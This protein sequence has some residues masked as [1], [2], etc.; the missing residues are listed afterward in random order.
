MC[1]PRPLQVNSSAPAGGRLGRAPRPA[2]R[3]AARRSSSA[4]APSR[5]CMRT[6]CPT[7][8]RSPTAIVPRLG[9]GADDRADEEVA[10]LVLG[11]VLVDHDPEHQA[12]RRRARCSRGSSSAIASRSRSIAGAR[13]ELARSRFRRAAVIVISGPTGVA[14]C[15]THGEHRRRPRQRAGD[16]APGEHVAVAEQRAPSRRRRRSP[17]R[18]APASRARSSFSA[19]EQRLGR[20]R[21]GI[22]EQDQAASPS[23][24]VVG[25]PLDARA[26]GR[27]LGAEVVG[28]DVARPAATPPRRPRPGP[29]RS[30]GRRPTTP[31]AP[32][33]ISARGLEPSWTAPSRIDFAVRQVR[34]AGEDQAQV[35]RRVERRP[36][37]GRRLGERLDRV[38]T[39]GYADRDRTATA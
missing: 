19:R 33:P 20:E 36:R 23:S 26:L 30:R 14:P 28:G 5:T 22:G 39:L 17:A 38:E 4:E 13:G 7:R 27:R 12:A 8:T 29:P 6:V 32:Q 15:E 21:V 34:G 31:P 11:L 24:S 25:Q 2:S 1:E 18:R 37:V 35:A 16:R 3:S 10:A 9:V